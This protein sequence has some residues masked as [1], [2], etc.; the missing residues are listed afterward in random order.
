MAENVLPYLSVAKVQFLEEWN[1]STALFFDA[2]QEL[3][4]TDRA[5]FLFLARSARSRAKKPVVEIGTLA[6]KNQWN[7]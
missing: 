4:L 3:L 1:V 6:R 2:P 5:W 7:I